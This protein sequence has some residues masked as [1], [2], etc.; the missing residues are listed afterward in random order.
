MRGWEPGK[1][2]VAIQGFGNAGQHAARLLH[3]D[4]YRIVAVSDSQGGVFKGD[5]F[6]VP[7]LREAKRETGR[8]QSVSSETGVAELTNEELL[9]LD[10][11]VLIPA[12][13][14][15]V[16]TEENAE[17][18]KASV[19]LELANGP[20]KPACEEALTKNGRFVVPDILANAGG[21]TV[22]YFEWVQN[23]IG[24]SWTA[25]DVHEKLQAILAR[26]LC[27]IHDF[28]QREGIDMRTAAY[29]QALHRIGEAVTAQGTSGYFAK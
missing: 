21:V 29:A 17:R 7:T 25:E 15:N 28:S 18:V 26:E 24:Y 14:E 22:S 5:G 27:A 11:D 10:V 13:L 16:I 12:A 9:E 1:A 19:I 2:K 6:D 8:V 23:H 3:A 4:G 20:I